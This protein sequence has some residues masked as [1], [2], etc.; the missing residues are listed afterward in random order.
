MTEMPE[1]SDHDISTLKLLQIVHRHG[2]R[3]VL[4]SNMP[5]TDPFKDVDQ[6]WAEGLGQL[7]NHGKYRMYAIGQYLR[8]SYQTYLGDEHSPREVYARSSI[9]PRYVC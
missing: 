7:T 5:K 1:W 6:Y 8:Q 3:T 9:E 4:K 2:E